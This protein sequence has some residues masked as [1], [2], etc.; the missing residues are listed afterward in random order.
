[1]RLDVAVDDDHNQDGDDEEE[2]K[3]HDDGGVPLSNP[4]AELV[5]A[6]HCRVTSCSRRTQEVGRRRGAD[7]KPR[8][9][10]APRDI[11]KDEAKSDVDVSPLVAIGWSCLL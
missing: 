4:L 3:H 8:R 5:F 10:T 11:C 7:A 9:Q 6:E 1:M 2:N